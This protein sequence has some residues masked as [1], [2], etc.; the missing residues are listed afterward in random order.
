M[1][2]LLYLREVCLFHHEF[3]SLIANDK[4]LTQWDWAVYAKILKGK[5]KCKVVR[6]KKGL[7]KDLLHDAV[8]DR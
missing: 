2:L 4:E 6:R 5:V 1:C 3:I 8:N 7:P